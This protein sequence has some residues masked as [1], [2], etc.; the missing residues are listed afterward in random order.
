[1][2]FEREVWIVTDEKGG[3]ITCGLPRNRYLKSRE[4]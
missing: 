3:L 1:M 4:Y 2:R